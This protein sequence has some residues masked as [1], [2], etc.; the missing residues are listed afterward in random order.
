LDL[1]EGSTPSKTE[2]ET[3]GRAGGGNVEVTVPNDTERK[4]NKENKNVEGTERNLS[5]RRS[6]RAYIRREL[7]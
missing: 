5:G 2:K 7:W 6:G 1:V 4:K 3:A